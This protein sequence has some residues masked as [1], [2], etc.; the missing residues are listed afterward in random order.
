VQSSELLLT[1]DYARDQQPDIDGQVNAF[2]STVGHWL[3][4]ARADIDSINARLEEQAR[5]AIAGRRKRI[6]QRDAHLAQ[7][8]IPVRRP[9][10][11]AKKTYIPD[12]LV[13]RPT[14]SLPKAR[15][16]AKAPTLEP[17]PEE[18][19]FEH[20][21]GV[22]RMLS[23]HMEQSPG[24]YAAM[25]EEDRRAQLWPRIVGG[26]LTSDCGGH[27]ERSTWRGS[28]QRGSGQERAQLIE[29]AI[30]GTFLCHTI[31]IN[32]LNYKHVRRV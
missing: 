26:E 23:R 20:I 4:F 18:R 2:I 16:D 13:R 9:G 28:T 6:E 10:E 27:R 7:S 19:I 3:G 15:A 22:L 29:P 32:M 31:V 11:S 25:S 30:L 5:Q 8:K 24:I 21:L 14:P 1:I 12:V 17:I